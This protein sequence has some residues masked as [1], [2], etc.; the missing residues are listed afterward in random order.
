MDLGEAPD[1][2]SFEDFGFYACKKA[3][4]HVLCPYPDNADLCQQIGYVLHDRSPGFRV[5]GHPYRWRALAEAILEY[6]DAR[7]LRHICCA[8]GAEV[9]IAFRHDRK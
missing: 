5:F 6:L 8:I 2:F 1:A 4:V 9:E 3:R 7:R